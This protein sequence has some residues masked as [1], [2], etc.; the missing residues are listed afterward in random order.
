M[1][2]SSS[3]FLVYF[4]PLFLLVYYAAA[5]PYKNGVLLVFSVLFY[6][7][8][9]PKFIFVLLGTTLLDFFL[10][11]WM[12]RTTN[13]R[14]RKIALC[15]SVGINISLLFYFKY[16]NFFIETINDVLHTAGIGPIKLLQ[17][18]MPIGISFY[19][20]ETMTYVVDVY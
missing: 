5:R 15:I 7:W 19:T 18:V 4:L 6:A 16:C 20:F 11:Q 17:V 9:A 8:G 1:V 10:V 2:F 14:W 3:L 12:D 13:Q